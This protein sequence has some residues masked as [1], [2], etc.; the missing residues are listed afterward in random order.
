MNQSHG[1]VDGCKCNGRVCAGCVDMMM[2]QYDDG[3]LALA[4]Q[5]A[6]WFE[7]AA[8]TSAILSGGTCASAGLTRDWAGAAMEWRGIG[9]SSG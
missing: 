2:C 3:N 5:Q 6:Y 4:V 1:H 7:K 8:L 9:L